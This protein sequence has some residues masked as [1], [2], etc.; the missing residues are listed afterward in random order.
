ML[1]WESEI[2]P[3]QGHHPQSKSETPGQPRHNFLVR[4]ADGMRLMR[5]QEIGNRSYDYYKEADMREPCEQNTC[6]ASLA[7]KIGRAPRSF[8]TLPYQL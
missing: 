3:N 8:H 6:H 2:R 5:K 1:I 7:V 4:Q